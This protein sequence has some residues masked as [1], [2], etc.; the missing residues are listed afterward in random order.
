MPERIPRKRSSKSPPTLAEVREEVLRKIAAKAEKGASSPITPAIREPKR[1]LLAQALADLEAERAIF[2][3]R[4]AAKPKFFVIDFAPSAAGAAGKIER[5]AA[6]RHP[7]LLTAAELKKALTKL[8][9]MIFAEAFERLGSSRRLLRLVRG[10]FVVFAHGDSLR[11]MLGDNIPAAAAPVS[12]E[13]IHRAYEDLVRLTGFPDVMVAA[14]Q[15]QSGVEMPRLKEWLL[16]EHRAGRAVFGL[17]DWSLADDASRAGVIE[18]RGD[19]H[20]LVRLER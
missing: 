5:F 18:L 13:E 19:R 11:G 12:A 4:T 17:G 16:A 6:L 9:Q 15:R 3:D 14:L 20:L 1:A 10:K 7:A 2:V 8:E